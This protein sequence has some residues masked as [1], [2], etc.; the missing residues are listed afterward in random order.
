MIKKKYFNSLDKLMS[1]CS[2]S[3]LKD[4]VLNVLMPKRTLIWE[5][6]SASVEGETFWGEF[7]SRPTDTGVVFRL[8]WEWTPWAARGHMEQIV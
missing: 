2:S 4:H 6:V 5:F 3:Q 1:G 8:R 7:R